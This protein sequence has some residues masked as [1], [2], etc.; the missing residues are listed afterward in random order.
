MIYE[1]ESG[2]IMEA[3]SD[4]LGELVEAWYMND[5]PNWKHG[6]SRNIKKPVMTLN[7]DKY[8]GMFWED[9]YD[10]NN[11]Y[12]GVHNN[13]LVISHAAYLM[14]NGIDGN[15][16][17]KLNEEQLAKLW[18]RAMLMMP[19]DCDFK[20]CR[21]LL[22]LAANSMKLTP[23]QIKCI[24]EAFDQVG[25]TK[26]IESPTVPNEYNISPECKLHV[27]RGDDNY[28]D[29]Y[30]LEITSKNWLGQIDNN[31][32]RRVISVKSGK[33]YELGLLE[34]N[35]VI[36]I[37]DNANPNT[38]E[39]IEVHVKKMG[40]KKDIIIKMDFG[41]IPIKGTVSEVRMENGVETNFPI[42][43]AVVTIV[44]HADDTVVKTIEMVESE[45]FFETYLPVGNY[46]ITA[47]ADG[48][49]S[50]AFSFEVTEKESVYL[51]IRMEPGSYEETKPILTKNRVEEFWQYY[52]ED[53]TVCH[54]ELHYN[55]DGLIERVSYSG[56]DHT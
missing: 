14:W 27:V 2:A 8:R 42:T 10:F 41:F 21:N 45:G 17:K 5:I 29:N 40:G 19:Q 28:Y 51:P 6:T 35:Y 48:Y 44:S 47:E 50:S 9:T 37:S 16:S 43:N 13:S 25:I 36:T 33:P 49:I 56:C 7:P 4:I 22:E 31:Q 46:T 26:N 1:G 15:E 38:K 54:A 24:G 11:D 3:L 52:M 23:K 12:G 30:S 55:S 32:F 20:Q 53:E 34:G 39:T 18:Y